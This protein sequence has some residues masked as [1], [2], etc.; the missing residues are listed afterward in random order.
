[1]KYIFKL[2]FFLLLLQLY[3]CANNPEKNIYTGIIE[4]KINQIPALTGGK[5]SHLFVEEGRSVSMGD[6]LALIDTTELALEHRQLKATLEEI[7]IQKRI[8]QTKENQA[9]S[10]LHYAEQEY[11]RM[12]ALVDGNVTP[13]QN[14]DQLNN[15]LQQANSAFEIARQ[16]TQ[17]ISAKQKQVLAQLE[18]LRKKITDAIIVAPINGLITSRYYEPGEAVP[19]LQ[20]LFELIRNDQMEVKIYISEN[21]LTSVYPGQEVRIRVDGLEIELPGHVSWISSKSEFT[22]KMILT[23]DTRTSL[24]YA[25]TISIA[26]TGNALKHGMPVEVLLNAE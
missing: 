3:Y 17:S 19:P 23:P 7:G 11:E 8:C 18:L 6:T 15:Q 5:I 26:N 14:L 1:M 22:P 10:D 9:E 25:V 13:K 21:Q 12:K 4:G 2:L 24:V 20:P 16:Q